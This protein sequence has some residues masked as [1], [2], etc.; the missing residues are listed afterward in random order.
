M[1]RRRTSRILSSGTPV[2]KSLSSYY[3]GMIGNSLV[4]DL[5]LFNY[6]RKANSARLAKRVS[7]QFQSYDN[8][9]TGVSSIAGK[10]D[11]SRT[12]GDRS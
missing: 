1:M 10:P 11:T 6:V 8:Y 2:P 12:R 4:Y 3:R 5:S 9:G 7:R